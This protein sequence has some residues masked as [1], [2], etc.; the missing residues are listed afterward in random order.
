MEHGTSPYTN[1]PL[2]DIRFFYNDIR[3]FFPDV[4]AYSY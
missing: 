2:I 3:N 4:R 1:F